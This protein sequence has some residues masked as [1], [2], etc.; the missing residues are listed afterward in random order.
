MLLH[1]QGHWDTIL[2]FWSVV[3]AGGV[4]TLSSPFSNVEEHRRQHIF[5]LSSLLQSPICI[6]REESLPTFDG[7]HSFRLCTVE[8][9]VARTNDYLNGVTNGVM[10]TTTERPALLMLTSGSTGTPKLSS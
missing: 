6:T 7:P 3:L 9:L 1:L 10:A 5:A 2:W 4:P 8:S